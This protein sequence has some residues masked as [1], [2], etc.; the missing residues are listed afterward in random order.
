MSKK[1]NGRLNR[2]EAS[3]TTGGCE[4]CAAPSVDEAAL[5]DKV[6]HDLASYASPAYH[7]QEAAE[8]LGEADR[9]EAAPARRRR[10]VRRP[11]RTRATRRRS[12]SR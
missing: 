9:R 2:L 5:A 7:R 4:Q 10:C 11:A 1:N 3:T 8:L 6:R 12:H